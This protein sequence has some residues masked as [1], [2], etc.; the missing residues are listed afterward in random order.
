MFHV[1]AAHYPICT[2]ETRANHRHRKL[3]SRTVALA[4]LEA[5]GITESQG[6]KGSENH[7]SVKTQNRYNVHE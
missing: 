6:W 5:H 4:C 7:V 3:I 1:A 2:V